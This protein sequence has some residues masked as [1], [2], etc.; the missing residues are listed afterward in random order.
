MNPPPLLQP[1]EPPRMSRGGLIAV[2]AVVTAVL[3]SLFW[4]LVL[5]LLSFTLLSDPPDFHVVIEAP[6]KVALHEEFDLK[7]RVTN[8]SDETLEIGSVD[9]A[10]SLLD[11][12]EIISTSPQPDEIVHVLGT[13]STYKNVTLDPGGEWSI[14]YRMKA[15]KSGVWTGDIDCC[16]PMEAFVT[17]SKT[18]V[19][20]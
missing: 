7:V 15:V 9:L 20:E 2:T 10:D 16:T 12:F 11:G 6:E 18:I 4:L 14:H 5:G 8:P 3:T 17:N 19:V 13:H 1:V